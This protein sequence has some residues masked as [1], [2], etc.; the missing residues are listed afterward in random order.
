MMKHVIITGGAGFIGSHLCD[1]FLKKGYA[2]TAVDNLITGK[3]ENLSHIR[4]HIHFHFIQQDVCD[5]L[6]PKKFSLIAKWGLHGVLHFACPASPVDFD[7]IPF[8]ILKVDS[9]GTI[10]TVD[11]AHHFNARYLLASTSEVYGDPLAHPQSE[12]YWGNVNPIGPRSCYDETKRF[13]EAYVS[14]AIRFKNLNAGIVRIFNTYGPRMRPDDGRIIP[15]LCNQI[16]SHQPMSIHG[17]GQQ[18]RSFCYIT[19]LVRGIIS[20][21]ESSLCEPINLGNVEEYSVL[22]L[23]QELLKITGSSSNLQYQKERQDDPKKRCPD[24]SKAK[25]LLGWFPQVSLQEGL[26]K[27]F[28]YFKELLEKP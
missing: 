21:F 10:S 13:A 17:S 15:Q 22:S 3:K 18:T 4:E 6:D 27:T 20:L 12:S 5:P 1:A 2:V 11:L 26:E 23:T 28:S 19:D 7:R 24:L 25:H 9:L 14:N 16:L 8:E